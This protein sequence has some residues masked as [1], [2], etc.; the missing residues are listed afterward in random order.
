M[1]AVG[2]ICIPGVA[3]GDDRGVRI[4][5]SSV[6]RGLESERDSLP[7]LISA[8]GHTPV[9][10]EDFGA[11]STPSR[12]A[13]LDGVASSDAYLM[14]LGPVYGHRFLETNQSPTHDEFVAAQAAGIPRL[15]FRK[16]GVEF[17]PEQEEFT[18]L[19]GDYGTGVFYSTFRDATDLQA[20]VVAAIRDLEAT[21]R[22]VTFAPLGAPVSASWQSDWSP[23]R[24]G[25]SPTEASL[26][27]HVIPIGD[28]SRSQREMTAISD[29]IAPKLRSTNVVPATSA[30]DVTEVD[31]AVG[32]VF[33]VER[34]RWDEPVAAQLRRIRVDASGQASVVT[35]LPRG[36]MAA[37]FDADDVAKQ[38]AMCLRLVGSLQMIRTSMVAVAIGVEPTM[39]LAVG[40]VA[41]LM[42]AS[43]VSLRSKDT[44]VRLEADEAVS[45]DALDAGADTVA[46]SMTRLLANKLSG[47]S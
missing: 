24:Y 10:F 18:K 7:G 4:F 5:I 15:V 45:L 11:Q 38:V 46:L 47:L 28:R 16:D 26:E 33:P 25:N 40:T 32:V 13:C 8:L 29:S 22:G 41:E 17:E 37:I 34:R 9:R 21:P 31:G 20:K 1:A 2:G 36:S 30:L 3:V 19:V 27:V 39:M 35:S 42:R 14:L 44:P 43:S 12:Q 6:R 23:Q